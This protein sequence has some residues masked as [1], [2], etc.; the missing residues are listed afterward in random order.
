M[1]AA[2][3]PRL[4][5]VDEETAGAADFGKGAQS[6]LR[7]LRTDE[8]QAITTVSFRLRQCLHVNHSTYLET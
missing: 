5:A 1:A 3:H 2:V 6:C 7:H 8:N 4:T